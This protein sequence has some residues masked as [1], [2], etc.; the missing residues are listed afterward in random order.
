[1]AAAL[2][3]AAADFSLVILASILPPPTS[4]LPLLLPLLLLLPIYSPLLLLLLLPGLSTL[5]QCTAAFAFN[6]ASSSRC[7]SRFSIAS[8][9]E[10]RA[11]SAD[12]TEAGDCDSTL[13]DSTA[14]LHCLGSWALVCL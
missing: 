1:M 12:P 10:H 4:G 9:A 8:T 11:Y 14:G 7:F 13:Y 5:L 2:F 6:M 3:R